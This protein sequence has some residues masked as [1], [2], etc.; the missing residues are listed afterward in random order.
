MNFWRART[1][2]KKPT[3]GW[4]YTDSQGNLSSSATACTCWG[5]GG[6]CNRTL[7]GDHLNTDM[8]KEQ[9]KDDENE[10][11]L[12]L[13][14][15]LSM[16]TKA[17]CPSHWN[18]N[19]FEFSTISGTLYCDCLTTDS[20]ISQLLYHFMSKDIKINCLFYRYLSFPCTLA[21]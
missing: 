20:L 1:K 2:R 14:N 17:K 21:S 13:T 12:D 15:M 16:T 9:M 8:D 7:P 10:D 6:C 5:G 4:I 18:I 11:Y 19:N 3:G